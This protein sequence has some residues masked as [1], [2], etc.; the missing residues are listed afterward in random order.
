MK[1]DKHSKKRRE[2]K[3]DNISRDKLEQVFLRSWRPYLWIVV[4]GLIVFF[5][6]LFFDFTTLDDT[7]LII[8]N[9]DY[10]SN[11]SNL[12]KIFVEDVFPSFIRDDAYYRPILTLSFM[13]DAQLGG[14][15]SMMYHLTNILLHLLV[16]C[17]VFAMLSRFF[18][19]TLGVFF[20]TLVFL[21]HPVQVQAIAWIPGRNDSL[22][23]L[24][25][26]FTVVTF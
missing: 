14:K 16:S 26:V 5:Q 18:G 22:L 4:M 23:A 20:M 21:V 19:K 1:K 24:F 6:I 15:S 8:K 17:S 10:I 3:V 12:P 25:S 2:L 13:F 9:Y 7:L 11:L